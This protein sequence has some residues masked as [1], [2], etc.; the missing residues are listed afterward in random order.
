MAHAHIHTTHPTPPPPVKTVVL[1][2]TMDEAEFLFDIT[3]LIGGLPEGL[4]GHSDRLRYALA[5]VNV[6]DKGR[7]ARRI[8]FTGTITAW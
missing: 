3:N 6:K 1:E 7:E 8:L 5:S 2:M 4:R